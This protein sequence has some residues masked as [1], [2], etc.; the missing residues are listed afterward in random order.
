MKKGRKG[1]RIQVSRLEC[2]NISK[3]WSIGSSLS[4][5]LKEKRGI[6]MSRN[7]QTT[8]YCTKC[9]TELVRLTRWLFLSHFWPLL[10]QTSFFEAAGA[11]E[12]MDLSLKLRPCIPVSVSE[13][14]IISRNYTAFRKNSNISVYF[15]LHFFLTGVPFWNSENVTKIIPKQVIKMTE[16]SALDLK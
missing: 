14:G 15:R 6:M 7:V 13:F 10:K 8:S 1:K 11:I 16:T 9:V 5:L 4:R 12:K 3:A 2:I